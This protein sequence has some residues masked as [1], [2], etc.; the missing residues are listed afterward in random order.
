MQEQVEER[1]HFYE[2]G[3]LPRKNVDV[4][5][6]RFIVH[7]FSTQHQITHVLLDASL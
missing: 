5:Q 1:L 4:M 2:S 6:V 7:G 3:D